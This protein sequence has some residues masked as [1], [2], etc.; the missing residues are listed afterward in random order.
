MK[1]TPLTLL[2]ALLVGSSLAQ[3]QVIYTQDF[4]S[5][6]GGGNNSPVAG[7]TIASTGSYFGQAF[8]GLENFNITGGAGNSSL[9]LYMQVANDYYGATTAPVATADT[10]VAYVAN[11]AYTLAFDF[12][13]KNEANQWYRDATF[14]YQLW[15][16]SPTGGGLQLGS[17]S[18]TASSG[19]NTITPLSLTSLANAGGSGNLFLVFS[20]TSPTGTGDPAGFRQAIIDNI[21]VSISA[22][23][24]EPSSF[25]ALS[26]LALLGY[27]SLARRR[28]AS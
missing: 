23:I 12:S 6:T 7:W 8:G 28:R 9:Q 10:G 21:S 19:I 17:G 2:G 13:G 24:P 27:A 1:S 20:S 22:P 15:A 25:A 14:T 26:G 3:A 5:G 18:V 4:N 16:G 11:T